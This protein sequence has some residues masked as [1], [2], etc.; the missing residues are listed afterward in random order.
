MRHIGKIANAAV[1]VLFVVALFNAAARPARSESATNRPVAGTIL[2]MS[3]PRFSSG[4]RDG[5]H[6]EVTAASATHMLDRNGEIELEQPRVEVGYADGSVLRL[7]GTTGLLRVSQD[8][9][10]VSGDVVLVTG[11]GRTLDLK[12]AT[13]DLRNNT[14]TSE[15]HIETGLK[16]ESIRAHHLVVDK[17]GAIILVY[18]A[19]V[20]PDRVVFFD[21]Y[22]LD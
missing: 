22:K 6:Y 4:T 12:D 10:S 1:G 7:S 15:T 8:T 17:S 16:T 11:A 14:L 20:G 2:K 5:Q 3:N 21:M 9:L 19:I 18:G 13:I